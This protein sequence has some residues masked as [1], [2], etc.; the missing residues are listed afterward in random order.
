MQIELN[1]YYSNVGCM[2]LMVV[3]C[4][5]PL[6]LSAGLSAESISL[7]AKHNIITFNLF[8]FMCTQTQNGQGKKTV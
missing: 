7:I 5:W 6:K 1:T 8:T 2:A 4:N 3:L